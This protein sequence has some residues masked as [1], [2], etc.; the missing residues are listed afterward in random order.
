MT[1]K[2]EKK[3]R[4][5]LSLADHVEVLDAQIKASEERTKALR[6]KRDKLISD[7]LAK[8]DELKRQAGGGDV[9]L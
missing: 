5:T 7:A 6:A 2:P 4:R 8:A 1:E 3:P 9:L